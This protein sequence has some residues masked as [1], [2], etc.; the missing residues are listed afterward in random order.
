LSNLKKDG[1]NASKMFYKG[2][3]GLCIIDEVHTI[4]GSEKT[5][6]I[7]GL[8]CSYKLIGLTATPS[9]GDE[10]TKIIYYWLSDNLLIS[11]KYNMKPTIKIIFFDS[12]MRQSKTNAYINYGGKFNLTRYNNQLIK[13]KIITNAICKNIVASY[14]KDRFP[15]ILGQLRK[16]L[17]SY[18]ST[19]LNDYNID[20]EKIGLFIGGSK[21]E[22]KDKKIVLSTF[23][24]TSKGIDNSNWDNLFLTSSFSK[25]ELLE[26]AIGRILRS[27]DGKQQPIVLDYVDISYQ[28]LIY[29]YYTRL[30]LYSKLNFD[31]TYHINKETILDANLVKNFIK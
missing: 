27:K 30:K 4:L 6:N 21:T 15:L 29:M 18:Q 14:N 26:Q 25:H 3:F 11:K 31:V 28:M 12:K 13:R 1:I 10:T 24:M 17:E 8:V 16:Q 5:T 9:R 23:K 19:L 22:E 20:P 2:N 7:V